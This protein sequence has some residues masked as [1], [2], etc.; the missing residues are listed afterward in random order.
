MNEALNGN[1]DE[2]AESVRA[3][4]VRMGCKAWVFKEDLS[5]SSDAEGFVPLLNKSTHLCALINSAAIFE[6]RALET[7]SLDDGHKRPQI[8]VTAPFLIESEICTPSRNRP[9]GR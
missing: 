8:K 4:I 5:D 2:E 6:S 9:A 1:S 7:T 3:Q